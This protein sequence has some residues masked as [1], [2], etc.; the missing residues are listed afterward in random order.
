MKSSPGNKHIYGYIISSLGKLVSESLY[1]STY[2]PILMKAADQRIIATQPSSPFKT[3]CKTINLLTKC[4][5]NA[6]NLV[7]LAKE[8]SPRENK[9]LIGLNYL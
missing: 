2:F 9:T 4:S 6:A 5:Q 8:I 3:G 1:R 7:P